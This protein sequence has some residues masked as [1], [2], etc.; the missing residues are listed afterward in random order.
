MIKVEDRK[1]VAYEKALQA[2]EEQSPIFIDELVSH[3]AISLSTFYTYFPAG[4]EELEEIKLRIEKFKISKKQGLRN[5]WYEGDNATTQVVLYKL[6]ATEEEHK[7]I[8]QSHV[9]TT[10]GGDKLE[11][12]IIMVN[13]ND[14]TDE[15]LEKLDNAQETS[16]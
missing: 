9:D 1:K 7:K 14:L 12:G 10:S 15:Q 2:I 4:S 16:D 3:L 13:P 8:T 11:S 5:K 6:L